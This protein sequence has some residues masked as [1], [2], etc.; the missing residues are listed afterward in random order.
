MSTEDALSSE[1]WNAGGN[2]DV[3]YTWY[4]ATKQAAEVLSRRARAESI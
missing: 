1:A 3:K 4:A 2:V